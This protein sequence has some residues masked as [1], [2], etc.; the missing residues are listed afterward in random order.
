M[1]AGIPFIHAGQDGIALVD[2]KYR[3]F[4]QNIELAIGN[5]RGNFD[6]HVIL[7]IQ[8][9]HFQVD[10]NQIILVLWHVIS[11]MASQN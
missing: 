6:N 4:C 5:N 10:P 8:T 3:A 11:R 1:L 9:G 7:C 2:R